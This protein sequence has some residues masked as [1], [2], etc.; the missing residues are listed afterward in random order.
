[1]LQFIAN[2]IQKLYPNK[3]Y[4]SYRGFYDFPEAM[5]VKIRG[6]DF[7]FYRYFDEELDDYDSSYSVYQLDEGTTQLEP[8]AMWDRTK[9]HLSQNPLCQIPIDKIEFDKNRRHWMESSYWGDIPV[10]AAKAGRD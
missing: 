7:F 1:M 2:L 9:A 6:R 3:V 10:T 4:F 8:D 5:I